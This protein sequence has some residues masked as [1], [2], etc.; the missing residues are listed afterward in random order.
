MGRDKADLTTLDG[1]SFLDHACERLKFH[2]P[3][4][5][6]SSGGNRAT[7]HKQ[8]ADPP[9]AHGPISGIHASLR[10]ARQENFDACLFN[11]VDTPFL[12]SNDLERL[13]Q[14]FRHNRDK[15]VCAVAAG[16][17]RSVEPLIAIYP[18]EFETAIGQSIALGQYSLWRLLDTLPIVHVALTPHA[19]QNINTP[20]D[21]KELSKDS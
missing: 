14:M 19:C 10:F 17:T 16:S 15:I 7:N 9:D 6:V 12:T 3:V 21:L 4:V 11:P 13:V 18:I 20:S 2:C 5:C 1:R 8:I